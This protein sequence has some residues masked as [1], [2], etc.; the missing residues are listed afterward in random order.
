LDLTSPY[1]IWYNGARLIQHQE[2]RVNEMKRISVEV[3]PKAH[4]RLLGLQV[5]L[6]RQQKPMPLK[7][8][9]KDAVIELLILRADTQ[10]LIGRG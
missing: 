8:I 3:S 4:K 9:P 10:A 6:G 5:K 1:Q 7:R 2:A